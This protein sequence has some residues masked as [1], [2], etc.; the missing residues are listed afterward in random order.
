MMRNINKIFLIGNLGV[1]AT[2]KI[3]QNSK[4]I[5]ILVLKSKIKFLNTHFYTFKTSTLLLI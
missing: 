4:I 2:H 3:F 1:G 5:E